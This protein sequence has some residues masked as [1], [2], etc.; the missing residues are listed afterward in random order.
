MVVPILG[1]HE[2]IVVIDRRT[3]SVG[4][5][6][7]LSNNPSSQ[8]LMVAVEGERFAQRLLDYQQAEK[9]AS[10]PRRCADHGGRA[11]ARR[12]PK[13]GWRWVCPSCPR[14]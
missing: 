13:G 12:G 5:L 7:A 2:K 3:T 14:G 10:G 9:L 11:H 6:N 1:L 4:S 8:E